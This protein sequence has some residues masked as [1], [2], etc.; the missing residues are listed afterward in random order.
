M[1]RSEL[2]NACSFCVSLLSPPS[3]TPLAH[4]KIVLWHVRIPFA[5]CPYSAYFNHTGKTLPLNAYLSFSPPSLNPIYLSQS[6]RLLPRTE[7]VGFHVLLNKICSRRNSNRCNR[8]ST[9]SRHLNVS[10][11][12]GGGS[13]KEVSVSVFR[14]TF[15]FLS[16]SVQG[17]GQGC[18]QTRSW[19][20]LENWQ[21]CSPRCPETPSWRRPNSDPYP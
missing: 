5:R 20:S 16:F 12:T 9:L 10:Y 6:R 7:S 1:A 21:C 8:R 18:A 2:A 15:S 3:S 13:R 4:L 11:H 14:F 19:R 17:Q